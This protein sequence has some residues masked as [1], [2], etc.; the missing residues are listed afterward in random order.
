VG[1]LTLLNK[2]DRCRLSKRRFSSCLSLMF[3]IQTA[4]WPPDR[5]LGT[6]AP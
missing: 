2:S 4:V 6:F 1:C 5:R 3:T